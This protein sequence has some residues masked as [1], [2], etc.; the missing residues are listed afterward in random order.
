MECNNSTEIKKNYYDT[1]KSNEP[2]NNVRCYV[3]NE[4]TN[5]EVPFGYPMRGALSVQQC[6]DELNNFVGL[7]VRN[8]IG[9]GFNLQ[10]SQSQALE[11]AKQIISKMVECE[12]PY[13]AIYDRYELNK[14]FAQLE[15]I[16]ANERN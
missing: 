5:D 4:Q 12:Y 3:L 2:N 16:Q 15:D 1:W 6:S 10:M 11:M 13:N 7:E 14:M 8:D 9:Q